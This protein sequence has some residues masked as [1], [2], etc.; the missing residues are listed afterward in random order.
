VFPGKCCTTPSGENLAGT[1][2][3][4][5]G[6][7]VVCDGPVISSD[8]CERNSSIGDLSDLS[9]FGDSLK[10]SKIAPR[11]ARMKA[12]IP[13]PADISTGQVA[14]LLKHETGRPD[15][16]F[17]NLPRKRRAVPAETLAGQQAQCKNTRKAT[18][19]RLQTSKSRSH[20]NDGILQLLANQRLG[21]EPRRSTGKGLV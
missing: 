6:R 19:C 9:N 21:P 12:N 3:G 10:R 8:Y 18:G 20:G 15:Q 1:P 11:K 4:Y 7:C 14:Q 17:T 16:G 5:S 13:R 2:K